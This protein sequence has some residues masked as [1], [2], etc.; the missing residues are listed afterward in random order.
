MDPDYTWPP[1]EFQRTNMALGYRDIKFARTDAWV[2]AKHFKDWRAHEWHH[3]AIWWDDT[4]GIGL[5]SGPADFTKSPAGNVPS[6]AD[7]VYVVYVDGV[8]LTT[9]VIVNPTGKPFQA[10]LHSGGPV[11]APPNQPPEAARVSFV[12]LNAAVQPQ[13]QYPI[14]PDT[15]QYGQ[16]PKDMLTIGSI[17]RE[18]ADRGGIYKFVPKV[19]LPAHGTIDDVRFWDGTPDLTGKNGPGG[20]NRYESGYWTGEVDLSDRFGADDIL[21]LGQLQF[22]AYLPRWWGSTYKPDGG[23]S[24]KVTISVLTPEGQLQ[25]SSDGVDLKFEKEFSAIGP[26]L[27]QPDATDTD[28]GMPFKALVTG[29]NSVPAEVHRYP[30]PGGTSTGSSSNV[31]WRYDRVQYKVEM[32]PFRSDSGFKVATPAL[33]DITLNY[34][35]PT[36]RVL[37]KEKVYD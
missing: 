29:K 16:Y 1:L 32:E 9:D 3:F 7:N 35:L 10:Q 26:S 11:Q 17:W 6:T 33:D 34:Y 18:Q 24:V 4:A 31:G 27:G 21:K 20:A 19:L 37:L 22:T 36:P 5:T 2:P 23:G 28:K 8:R 13:A 14:T 25:K 12:R 15:K 30:P